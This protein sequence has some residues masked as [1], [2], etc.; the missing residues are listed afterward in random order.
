VRASPGGRAAGGGGRGSAPPPPRPPLG[1]PRTSRDSRACSR[2]RC[3]RRVAPIGDVSCLG[4]GGGR[5]RH[6]AQTWPGEATRSDALVALAWAR[7]GGGP[8]QGRTACRQQRSPVHGGRYLPNRS[9]SVSVALRAPGVAGRSGAC[10][11]APP[12]DRAGAS[13][14][15][16][17]CRAPR[18]AGRAAPAPP[19][20]GPRRSH[21]EVSREA[22]AHVRP[23][24]GQN[25]PPRARHVAARS[26]ADRS[27]T[28]PAPV[29]RDMSSLTPRASPSIAPARNSRSRS[30][31]SKRERS[32]AFYLS[33]SPTARN[34][35][36][37]GP[38]RGRTTSTTPNRHSSAR[39]QRSPR[40][41]R[42][43]L[44]LR[45]SRSSRAG[46]TLGVSDRARCA[47]DSA[48]VRQALSRRSSRS[49]SQR[50][51]QLRSAA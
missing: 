47:S 29:G 25:K 37:S 44:N 21:P 36:E 9:I 3:A 32:N 46:L 38:S 20:S 19:Q 45:P 42:G 12:A 10:C 14:T 51:C 4:A 17:D 8:P 11:A 13:A 5:Q 30:P 43:D 41:V 33:P 49:T 50:D 31:E 34:H 26:V 28:S 7:R 40:R 35:W 48:V 16:E 23:P 39:L 6:V 2:R 15:G 24:T 1:D 27:D 18:N 22:Y